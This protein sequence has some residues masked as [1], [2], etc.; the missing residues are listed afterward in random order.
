M[1]AGGDHDICLYFDD[2]F[3]KVYPEFIPVA[4][5][6]NECLGFP[7]MYCAT[8]QLIQTIMNRMLFSFFVGGGLINTN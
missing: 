2:V 6:H 5:S 3:I 4:P 1:C 8:K 7:G